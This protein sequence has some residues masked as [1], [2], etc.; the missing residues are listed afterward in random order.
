MSTINATNSLLGSALGNFNIDG[1]LNTQNTEKN[2]SS[3]TQ[4]ADTTPVSSSDQT[5]LSQMGQLLSQLQLQSTTDP[6]AFKS[7]AKTIADNLATRAGEA[8]SDEQKSALT[9]LSAKFAEASES[10]SMSSLT[11]DSGGL[12]SGGFADAGAGTDSVTISDEAKTRAAQSSSTAGASTSGSEA[13]ASSDSSTSSGSAGTGTAVAGS[14]GGTSNS[15]KTESQIDDLIDDKKREIQAAQGKAD[16]AKA[17]AKDAA[18]GSDESK[19]YE[20]KLST[21]NT[22]LAVLQSEKIQAQS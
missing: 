9:A 8:T 12:A 19:T 1:T 10:G 17:Q 7:T 5:S 15:G 20:T 2:S 21:L 22:E 11:D 13:E 16:Q 18:A 4:D 6:T 14:A 3:A